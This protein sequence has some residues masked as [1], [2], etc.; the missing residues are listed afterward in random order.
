MVDDLMNSYQLSDELGAHE[1]KVAIVNLGQ[2]V[3]GNWRDRSLPAIRSS[4]RA[5]VS[6]RSARRPPAPSRVP[7]W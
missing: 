5:S 3:S 4:P 1:M 6:S 7:T 2:I